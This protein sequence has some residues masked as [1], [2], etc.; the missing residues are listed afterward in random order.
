MWIPAL[1]SHFCFLSPNAGKFSQYPKGFACIYSLF[2]VS[3]TSQITPPI[4]TCSIFLKQ[5]TSPIYWSLSGFDSSPLWSPDFSTWLWKSTTQQTYQTSFSIVLRQ[6][7]TYL[8]SGL[9]HTTVFYFTPCLIIWV[10]LCSFFFL[11]TVY[12]VQLN[13]WTWIR[14]HL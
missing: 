10:S 9:H 11:T 12:L 7:Q 4:D 8:L 13:I 5:Y 6:K 3:C 2:W 1:P 14:T